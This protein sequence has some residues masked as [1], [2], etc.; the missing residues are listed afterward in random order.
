MFYDLNTGVQQKKSKN[1][2][3][4]DMNRSSCLVL[5]GKVSQIQ[6]M[7]SLLNNELLPFT[8]GMGAPFPE[9]FSKG[10][11]VNLQFGDLLNRKKLS[12]CAVF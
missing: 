9:S 2:T 11:V 5:S 4:R 12:K 7:K 3:E 8:V 1:A 6:Q 10:V